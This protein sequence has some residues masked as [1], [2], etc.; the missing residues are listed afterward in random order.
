MKAGVVRMALIA[1]PAFFAAA[2]TGIAVVNFSRTPIDLAAYSAFYALIVI[3]DVVTPLRERA[4]WVQVTAQLI[5][6]THLGP[7]MTKWLFGAPFELSA[8]LA[9]G[10]LLLLAVLMLGTAVLSEIRSANARW[11]FSE[12]S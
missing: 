11:P 9:G 2:F 7:V 5:P 3:V 8:L 1:L 4:H 10:Y 6:E 12:S